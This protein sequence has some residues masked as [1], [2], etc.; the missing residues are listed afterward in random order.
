MVDLAARRHRA[1]VIARNGDL[2]TALA[3]GDLDLRAKLSVSEASLLGLLC[4]EVC[5][6]FVVLG[7]GSTA[8]A[9]VL[10]TYTEAGV[11]RC[12]PVRHETE[13]S[14]AAVASRWLFGRRAAVVTSIGPGGL[15]ALAGSLVA[16]S[17]GVG[18]WY[19]VGDETTED[20]GP[21]MQQLLG[22]RQHGFLRLA[23]EMGSAYV[24]H[25]PGAVSAAL[26][27]GVETT[28]HPYRSGPFF[29]LLPMNT[30]ELEIESFNLAELPVT[31]PTALGSASTSCI[32]AAAELLARAGHV[33]VKVGGGGRGLRVEIERLLDAVDG[34][35][36]LSPSSSDVLGHSHPRN[37]LVGG[38]KGSICGNYAMENARTLIVI[39]SRGVCQADCSR[40]G[41]PGVTDV[42][43]INA[44]ATEAMH[45]QRT[46]ALVGDAKATLNALVAEL[47]AIGPRRNDAQQAWIAACAAAKEQWRG[48]LEAR[49]TS[50]TLHDSVWKRRVLTQPAAID[51][52]GDVVFQAG[53]RLLFDAGDVQ[54]N[55]FQ[56]LRPADEGTVFTESGAS[57]MGFAASGLL[58]TAVHDDGSPV[59]AVVGD[60]SFTMNPQVLIDAVAIG[61]YGCVVVLDNRR[62]G[63]IS[64]LQRAQYGID[65]ATSDAVAVDYVAWASAVDGVHAFH[66]GYSV[67]EL[68]AAVVEALARPGLTFVHVP[69]Y[70]G[71]DPLGGLGSFGRWNVGPWVTDTQHLR[72]E[73]AL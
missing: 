15:H 67:D 54:A 61:A 70:F 29:L 50:P 41:Y 43:N 10:R 62:M 63:A 23:S 64:S 9:E 59:V 22:G 13:A 38:S 72:H 37:M 71:D 36:V 45:Y 49:R 46:L 1:D 73:L 58:A 42:V 25:T 51:T 31:R 34:V 6:F 57:Y 7:H 35:A 66:G 53:G 26:R 39:G 16:A 20:E 28:E 40:T 52:I 19:L 30:Q 21:N 47:Q 32:R 5:D 2:R 69:V 18:V 12:H 4:Q 27:R 11:T 3:T 17:N 60:G 33:V 68:R 48:H 24:L 55:G 14:H 8:F 65:F 44:D 56:M